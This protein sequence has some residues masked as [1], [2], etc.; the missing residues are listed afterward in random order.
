MTFII[1]LM[2]LVACS[3]RRNSPQPDFDPS[4]KTT[5]D[6]IE[7][8]ELKP[9][10]VCAK[11]RREKPQPLIGEVCTDAFF[12]GFRKVCREACNF[13]AE[14]VAAVANGGEPKEFKRPKHA[15]CTGMGSALKVESCQ[16]G[17]FDAVDQTLAA[18]GIVKKQE[19]KR[20]F[21][22][23]KES[24]VKVKENEVEVEKEMEKEEVKEMT[25]HKEAEEDEKIEEEGARGP[26]ARTEA[27]LRAEE[28][29]AELMRLA[30]KQVRQNQ[31]VDTYLE[32]PHSNGETY[33]ITLH[34]REPISDAVTHFCRDILK[35]E[36]SSTC[37][38]E[39]M[40][41]F[42]MNFP[43]KLRNHEEDLDNY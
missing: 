31:D 34:R 42:K 12:K 2:L 17:Y 43:E 19:K 38:R 5:C 40:M 3:A 1:L 13:K 14:N 28:N 15:K 22:G 35:S 37:S 20:L 7:A 24:K 16:A 11:Y 10:A 6:S 30:D 39:I 23:L 18:L 21:L 25:V 4:C 41:F 8:S 33:T 9:L 26:Q 36:D 32:F 29:K 27:E